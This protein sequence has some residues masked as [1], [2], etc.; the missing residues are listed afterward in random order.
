MKRLRPRFKFSD[1][2]GTFLEVWRGSAWREMNYFTCK[3]YYERGGHYHKKTKELFFFIDG[4]CE[5]TIIDVKTDRK[6]SFRAKHNDIFIVEP[7][8]AHYIKAIEDSKIVTVLDAV[9]NVDKPD[10]FLYERKDK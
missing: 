6:I 7:Y 8:E 1:K 2:R 10:I 3:K 5:V 4:S 9:H